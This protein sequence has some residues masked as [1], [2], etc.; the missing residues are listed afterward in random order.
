MIILATISW[1]SLEKLLAILLG[2]F[3]L[4]GS[5]MGAFLWVNTRQDD[6]INRFNS[7]NLRFNEINTRNIRLRGSLSLIFQKIS[8]RFTE[9]DS[10]ISNV[11]SYLKSKGYQVREKDFHHED[12]GNSFW[13]ESGNEDDTKIPE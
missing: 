9:L 10:R 12:Y 13:N 3:T 6:L 5:I 7:I 8:G 2:I 4:F 1:V 11:E